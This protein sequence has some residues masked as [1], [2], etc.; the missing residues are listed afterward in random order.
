MPKLTLHTAES[1][2]L[3]LRADLGINSTEAVHM[4]T[5]IRKE[6]I[7]TLYRPMSEHAYGLSLRHGDYKFMLI[8]SNCTRGRQ[9]FTIAHEFYHLYIEENP[10]PH[11]CCDGKTEEEYNADLFASAFL[12]PRDA[13]FAY[14]P[15]DEIRN[16]KVSLSII[17][18]LEQYFSVS[19]TALLIRLDKLG[20][21]TKQN[22]DELKS[23]SPMQSA[24]SYGYDTS[25]YKS[26]N[27]NLV[28]GDFG[29]IARSLFDAG[30]ISEGHYME[31]L[32]QIG[33]E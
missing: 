9:H 5:L 20:V 24:I 4:K 33:N 21:L 3:K 22:Y 28:I 15:T 19:R 6:N 27:E 16:K 2:A 26:G 8:N 14:I 29:T 32:N 18:K 10:K 1:L 11:I 31:L 30:K 17:L 25:L 23:F 7:L 13:I 12:M